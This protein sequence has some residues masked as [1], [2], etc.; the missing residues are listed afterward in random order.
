MAWYHQ[1]TA[2][3]LNQFPWLYEKLTRL[4]A[5]EVPAGVPDGPWA[6]VEKDPFQSNLLLVTTGGVHT[7]EQSPFDME[8]SRGD[9][10]YRWIPGDQETFTITHDYYDHADADRDINCLYP[11]PLARKLS[12]AQLIG[13]LSER[14]LSFMGHIEDPLLPELLDESLPSVW[15]ELTDTPDFILLSPG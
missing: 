14:H 9:A 12:K 7:P 11:L 15:E 10:S 1:L 8:D 2:R 4:S 3:I 6:P 13:S 5:G